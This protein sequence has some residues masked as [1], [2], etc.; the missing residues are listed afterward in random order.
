[1]THIT[2]SILGLLLLFLILRSMIRTALMNR[3]YRDFFAEITGRSVYTLVALRLRNNGDIRAMHPILLWF[4]PAYILLLT[5]VYFAGAMTAFALLY[6]GTRAINTWHQAFLASGSALNTLGFATPTTVG[7][8]WLAI[9]S[10]APE[11]NLSFIPA[12]GKQWLGGTPSHVT[13]ILGAGDETA[14][15][16]GARS[17]AIAQFRPDS[18]GGPGIQC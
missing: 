7:G 9:P 12:G 5:V 1:M 18:G 4:F 3:H 11:Q 14:Q 15:E 13:N 2:V 6:W 8:Q 17:R 10:Q 16:R